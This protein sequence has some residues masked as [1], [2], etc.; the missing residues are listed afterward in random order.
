MDHVESLC[1][2][3]VDR[4]T[5]MTG[6]CKTFKYVGNSTYISWKQNNEM[7][8]SSKVNVTQPI[9]GNFGS[10]MLRSTALRLAHTQHNC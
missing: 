4:P 3:Q 5:E 10:S 7:K 8:S 6:K 2:L 1:V 9:R